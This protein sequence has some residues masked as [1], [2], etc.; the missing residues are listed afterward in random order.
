MTIRVS[1]LEPIERHFCSPSCE[2]E[3]PCD[4]CLAQRRKHRDDELRADQ[5]PTLHVTLGDALRKER[6]A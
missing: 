6:R 3:G 2:R 4:L 1:R 5:K